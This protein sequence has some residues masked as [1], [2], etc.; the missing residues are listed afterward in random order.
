MPAA[1]ISSRIS[2]SRSRGSPTQER[3]AIASM[4]KSRLIVF[5]ISTVRLRVVPP[6]P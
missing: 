4:P 3:C 2:T 6:A 5:V 1:S